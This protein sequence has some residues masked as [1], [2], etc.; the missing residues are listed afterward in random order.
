MPFMQELLIATS[1]P[2]KIEEL[3]AMLEPLGIR[4]RS[5]DQLSES[6]PE[7]VEDGDTFEA[8]AILKARAYAQ[9]T[10][11]HCLADDSGLEVDAL[12]GRPGVHSA[13]F[14]G[15]EGG[16]DERDRANNARLLEEL[17]GLPHEQRSA[18]FVCVICV[19]RPDGSVLLTERGTVEGHIGTAPRGT[20]G[21]G[22]D[23]LFELP[24]GRT[25]AELPPEEKNRISH[26]AR[27][28]EGVKRKILP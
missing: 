1:N 12:D 22:Y 9:A 2:H 28:A 6:F 5:L 7:P 17:G 21:F 26:R 15:V 8:N 20:N 16:R 14:A 27:A 10:G 24:D 25:S 11:L 3:A 13:R 19:A 4:I 18:R 23:P